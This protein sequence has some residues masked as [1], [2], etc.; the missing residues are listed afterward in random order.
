M[1]VDK[2]YKVYMQK[3]LVM[4]WR[5][6]CVLCVDVYK[7]IHLGKVDEQS[8]TDALSMLKKK[9]L[10]GAG[11]GAKQ[12]R[13]QYQEQASRVVRKAR[14]HLATWPY[15]PSWQQTASSGLS[16]NA[17]LE[18]QRLPYKVLTSIFSNI[19]LCLSRSSSPKLSLCRFYLCS[20]L[21]YFSVEKMPATITNEE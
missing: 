5:E 16:S 8:A 14:N 21:L 4:Q 17:A 15:W 7:F 6:C 9:A 19:K 20:F 12:A 1:D 18:F 11:A 10:P 3:I 13:Q 2:V